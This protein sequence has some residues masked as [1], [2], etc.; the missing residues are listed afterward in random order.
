MLAILRLQFA[1]EHS[2]DSA[3]TQHGMIRLL[4]REVERI[5][6]QVEYAAK[7]GISPQYLSNILQG[8][9]G[10]GSDVLKALGL[11]RR[12]LYVRKNGA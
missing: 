11:E 8:H 6:S 9:R 12:V 4:K 2:I 3:M 1:I 5:G 7:L 10:P